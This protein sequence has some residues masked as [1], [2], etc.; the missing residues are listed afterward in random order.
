MRLLI[1]F[2]RDYPVQSV[3]VLFSLLLAGF[4]EGVGLSALLPFLSIAVGGQAGIAQ[5][6]GASGSEAERLAREIL[7]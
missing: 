6:A 7:L 3:I 5:S 2:A 1:K 4:M